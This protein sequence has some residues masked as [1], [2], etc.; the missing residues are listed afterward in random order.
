MSRSYRQTKRVLSF[1]EFSTLVKLYNLKVKHGSCNISF[2][3]Q[4]KTL[5][6]ILPSTI[7]HPKSMFKAK[8]MLGALG[9]KYEKIH[10]CSN[11]CCLYPKKYANAVRLNAV[12]LGG[13]VVKM[14]KRT[15]KF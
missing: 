6:Y 12:S 8:K 1:T 9:M 3:E 11:N 4:L 5:K 7:D 2:S 10:A 15:R 13:N 14:Q